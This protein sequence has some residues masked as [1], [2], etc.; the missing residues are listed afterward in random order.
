M[1]LGLK[2]KVAIVTGAAHQQG[3]GRAIAISLAKEGCD[4]AC[5]DIDDEGANEVA[6]QIQQMGNKSIGVSVN[7]SDYYQ[8]K[9]AV[10]LVSSKMG[11][12]DI[13]INNAALLG[14]TAL[15]HKMNIAEWNR[16]ISINLCGPFYFIKEAIPHMLSQHW[17]RI[18]NISSIA[19][20]GGSAGQAGYSSTKAALIGLT[21]TTAIEY[22]HNSITVNTLCLGVIDSSGLYLTVKPNVIDRL[23]N[24]TPLQRF[25]T[26]EEVS[27]IATFIVSDKCSFL[28]GSVII[29]DGGQTLFT[30]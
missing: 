28:T 23:R 18:L 27:S 24:V 22:A 7:Q 14:N 25:G 10:D 2:G 21:K 17:G 15:S 6:S 30:Y 26:V 29:M 9:Q 20:I 13:L 11:H 5:L 3:I 1:D 12:V 19:G 4:I 8:V 16:E